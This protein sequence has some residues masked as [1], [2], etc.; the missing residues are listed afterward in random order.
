MISGSR[1]LLR[2][3]GDMYILMLQGDKITR[4]PAHQR[5]W[6]PYPWEPAPSAFSEYRMIPKYLAIIPVTKQTP[7]VSFIIHSWD[8]LHS[9]M[10]LAALTQWNCN[11]VALS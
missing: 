10:E 3:R 1:S 11:G 8:W 7:G 6:D 9:F 5:K 4:S 2:V